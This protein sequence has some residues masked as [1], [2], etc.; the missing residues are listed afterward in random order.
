MVWYAKIYYYKLTVMKSATPAANIIIGTLY[1]VM[2]IGIGYIIKLMFRI[3]KAST[4]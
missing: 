4:T 1:L 2:I 3:T